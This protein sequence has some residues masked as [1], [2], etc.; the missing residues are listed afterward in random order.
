MNLVQDKNTVPLLAAVNLSKSYRLPSKVVEV[1]KGASLEVREGEC[2]A[3]IGRSG[4]GKSTL[5]HVLGG[6]DRPDAGE[7]FLRGQSLYA[8][9]PARRTRLRAQNVGFVFQAY[10]LLPEMDVTENV[11]LPAMAISRMGRAALR[12]RA[13]E[14]L[15]QVGLANRACHMPLE[16]S[17]GEQQR[18]AI[19]RALMNAPELLLADEPTGNLDAPASR[20]FCDL[21]SEMNEATGCT[22]LL[23]SH[24]PIVA[25]AADRVHILCGGRLAAPFDTLHDSGRVA[26][27]Y[28]ASMHG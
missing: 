14:L 17:G 8:L 18:V 4:A 27:R 20:A 12:M 19:A 1:L 28:L 9:S 16:L 11:L 15:D 21:L 5:L 24:D 2:V 10:H 13:L 6:L 26:E 7:V 25:A 23:V 22:I 3:I